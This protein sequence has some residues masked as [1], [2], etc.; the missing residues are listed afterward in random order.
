MGG[1]IPSS[2]S[3]NTTEEYNGASWSSGGTLA[4]TASNMSGAGTQTAGLA[5][6]GGPA[7]TTCQLYNGTS[8]TP[9]VS[10]STS[11]T[12]HGTTGAQLEALAIGAGAGSAAVEE[13]NGP[14]PS[15]K[16]IT[17]S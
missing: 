11:R 4:A 1:E 3:S 13:F 7:T 17:V 12:L 6:G 15:T 10:M 8:F 9:T 2:P 16:T 5:T 14:G